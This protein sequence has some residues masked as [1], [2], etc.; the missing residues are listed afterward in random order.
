MSGIFNT[1]VVYY[2][3]R[4]DRSGIDPAVPNDQLRLLLGYERE[5]VTNLT[6]AFQYYLEWTQDYG[7]LIANSLSPQFEPDEYRQVVTNRL[8]YRLQQDKLTL[9]LFS[10]SDRLLPIVTAMNGRSVAVPTCSAV[11]NHTRFSINLRTTAMLTFDSAT[12][13]REETYHVT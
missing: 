13:I 4:D 6:V 2:A 3:S 7:A 9:S 8:T 1:E 5:A 10:T 12:A 11:M